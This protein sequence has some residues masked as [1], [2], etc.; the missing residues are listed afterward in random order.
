MFS[1][2]LRSRKALVFWRLIPTTFGVRNVLGTREV[3]AYLFTFI[4]PNIDNPESALRWYDLGFPIS[5]TPRNLQMFISLPAA[6]LPIPPDIQFSCGAFYGKWHVRGQQFQF[7]AQTSS[8]GNV[9]HPTIGLGFATAVA[10]ILQ[11]TF[12]TIQLTNRLLPA[13][14]PH[15][16]QLEITVNAQTSRLWC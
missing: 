9:K 10:M 7:I 14:D 2:K 4:P 11:Q 15:I 8:A 6:D 16:M 13:F 12:S 3:G 5:Q 1:Q